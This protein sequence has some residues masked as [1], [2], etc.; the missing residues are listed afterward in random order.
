MATTFDPIH[1]LD[2]LLKSA[3]PALPFTATTPR[4]ALAW[5]R[6]AR[7]ALSR[8]IGFQ[9]QKRVPLSP[10]TVHE[11]DRGWFVR[12]KVIIRTSAASAMPMYLVIP[13]DVPGRLPCVLALHGH[14]YGAKDL[15][16]LWPDGAERYTP[17]GYHKDFGLE[18]ARRGFMVLAP[19]IS[20]F[21]ERQSDY[22]H[23]TQ[24]HRPSTCH[25][26]ST[27]ASMLGGS[28]AGIRVFDGMRAVD[29]LKTLGNADVSRLGVMGISGGGMHAFF[30]ACLDTRIRAAVISGYFCDWR[31]SI[32]AMNHCGCNFV[33]GILR[34][35]ELSDLSALIAPRPLLIE[36][37]TRDE[38][39]PIAAVKRTVRKARAAW[40]VFD[41]D[42]NL[43]TDCF[44]GTHQISGAKAYDFLAAQLG[45]RSAG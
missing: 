7:A 41:A 23:L 12:R 28:V 3:P 33:P 29:Y 16:G 4:R 1:Q 13:K 21:G 18:L 38:I 17:E 2:A 40:R 32:L 37:G 10:R 19:E 34:L 25:H 31:H 24:L 14:G 39:F 22:S 9:D 35:G 8:L 26:I 5:Q 11:V 15:V 27:F 45:S 6:R 42:A 43:Q 44:P 20:C 30:S 36:S